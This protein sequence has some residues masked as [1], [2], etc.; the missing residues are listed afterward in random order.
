MND[1]MPLYPEYF[2]RSDGISLSQSVAIYN[3]LLS[4]G[5]LD[6]VVLT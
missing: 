5:C 4:N 6:E 2:M 3:D 1:K